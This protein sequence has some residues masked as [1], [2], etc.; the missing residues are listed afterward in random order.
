MPQ[1]D[2]A[3]FVQ[4]GKLVPSDPATSCTLDAACKLFCC[5]TGM[6]S[7]CTLVPTIL[8]YAT[9]LCKHYVFNT[10][11]T[12]KH[13]SIRSDKSWPS[14]T[15]P[16]QTLGTITPHRAL[17]DQA[18]ARSSETNGNCFDDTIRKLNINE[19]Q[20][21]DVLCISA[22][23]ESYYNFGIFND[24]TR[25]QPVLSCKIDLCQ[26]GMHLSF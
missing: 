24:V 19:F 15:K 22:I 21:F 5:R 1:N 7:P 18:S 8:H 6:K 12:R 2:S 25:H 3:R 10:C 4:I 23:A 17:L 13:C 16:N 26:Q 11:H 9:P 14:Q 20:Q